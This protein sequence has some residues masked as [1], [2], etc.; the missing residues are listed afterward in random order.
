MYKHFL[1]ALKIIRAT[2]RAQGTRLGYLALVMF[3]GYFRK[4]TKTSPLRCAMQT[5]TLRDATGL[6]QMLRSRRRE[7][8]LTQEQL[9]QRAGL[10]AKHVSRIENGTHEP[11]VSTLF[12]LISALDLDLVLGNKGT[13]APVPSVT[14]IF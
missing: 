14:D 10:A 3:L 5:Q 9:G 13:V 2:V 6:S 12:A 1:F 8:G 7:L 4:S 11:K